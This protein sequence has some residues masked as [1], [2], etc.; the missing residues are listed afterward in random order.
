MPGPGYTTG[1]IPNGAPIPSN[2]APGT[3][4]PY[5]VGA[6]I[7]TQGVA[8]YIGTPTGRT[9]PA[10]RP[11]GEVAIVPG[12][13][14][15]SRSSDPCP[16]PTRHA[17]DWRGWQHPVAGAEFVDVQSDRFFPVVIPVPVERILP[18]FF[19]RVPKGKTL[20]IT[21][22][23][24]TFSPTKP[25]GPPYKFGLYVS[26]TL[27]S[28]TNGTTSAPFDTGAVGNPDV[29]PAD[30][31]SPTWAIAQGGQIVYVAILPTAPYQETPIGRLIGW[32][33][34]RDHLPNPDPTCKR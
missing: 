26:N 6:P 14:R 32:Q 10:A 18:L 2:L 21:K 20:L 29:I 28:V 31:L 24:G 11:G 16:D 3:R 12:L 22:W 19:F 7:N 25:L 8:P 17:Q 9:T 1:N 23:G 15:E 13:D 27:A 34:P 5:T 30:D 4:V 33:Y